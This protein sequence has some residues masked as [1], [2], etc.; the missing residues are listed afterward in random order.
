MLSILQQ[1]VE[2]FERLRGGTGLTN[3]YDI[4]Q[5]QIE[6]R[7]KRFGHTIIFLFLFFLWFPLFIVTLYSFADSILGFP[8]ELFTLDWY[9]TFFN[10]GRAIDATITSFMIS[11]IAVPVAV[12]FSIFGAYAIERYTFRGRGL[13]ALLL[14]LPIIVP[15]VVTGTALMLWLSYIGLG[16]GFWSVV[17]AHIVR[18]IPFATLV[19][20]PSFITFDKQLEEVSL[21][22]GANEVQTFYKVTIPNVLPGIVAGFFL[23]FAISFNEFVYTLFTRDTPTETLPIFIWNEIFHQATPLINVIS[24]LFILIAIIAVALGVAVTSVERIATRGR[25]EVQEDK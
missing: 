10:T 17:I 23:A 1:Y 24:V 19:I 16:S 14:I 6:R 5:R 25:T 18:C 22:L 3:V 2:R 21:D 13:F 12:L 9:F 8:P 15:L 20:L 7:G 11:G 4:F